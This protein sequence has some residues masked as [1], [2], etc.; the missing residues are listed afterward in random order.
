MPNSQDPPNVSNRLL[1]LELLHLRLP[2]RRPFAHA[3]AQRS[4]TETVVVA[5][6]LA[7][8]T[9]G[10]GE[11]LPRSYVTGETIESVLYNIYDTFADLLVDLEPAGLPELLERLDSLPF[12]NDQN[13]LINTARC[14]VELALL[15]AYGR[16][17]QQDLSAIPGWIGDPGLAGRPSI[18]TI[19]VSG[20][21]GTDHP[22]RLVRQIRLMRLYGLRHFK[23]KVGSPND[24]H[25]L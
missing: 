25:N 12:T 17:F 4:A 19:P 8:G 14:A 18:E 10:Y 9:V 7:D 2:F 3:A 5:A 13:Q 24:L 20:V 21:L 22:D 1:E 6:L 15:D 23:L 16:H 11:G